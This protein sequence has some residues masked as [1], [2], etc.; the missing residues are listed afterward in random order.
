MAMRPCK[1]SKFKI[2]RRLPFILKPLAVVAAGV[3]AFIIIDP[4][5]GPDC[6]PEEDLPDPRL[7]GQQ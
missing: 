3:A 7:P 2:K 1:V 5:F 6:D 4:C